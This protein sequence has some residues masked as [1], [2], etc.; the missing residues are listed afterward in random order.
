MKRTGNYRRRVSKTRR[1]KKNSDAL[2]RNRRNCHECNAGKLEDD[3]KNLI[4]PYMNRFT[5]FA[6]RILH[7]EKYHSDKY[8]IMKPI[9]DFYILLEDRSN[10]SID[11]KDNQT[12]L[13]KITFN[14]FIFIGYLFNSLPFIIF[15]VKSLFLFKLYK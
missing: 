1:S 12:F 4:L 5:D 10:K 9:D 8:K 2:V 11:S 6:K 14:C 15:I 7:D 13:L 3:A